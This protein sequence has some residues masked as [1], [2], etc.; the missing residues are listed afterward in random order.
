MTITKNQVAAKCIYVLKR[1]TR[2]TNNRAM[3]Q[4]LQTHIDYLSEYGL[5]DNYS[6][7]VYSNCI[8]LL[9]NNYTSEP[10]YRLFSD[11]DLLIS[12]FDPELRMNDQ[13][14]I[15]VHADG[16]A[17][18]GQAIHGHMVGDAITETS[19]RVRG[20]EVRNEYEDTRPQYAA[21]V[22]NDYSRNFFMRILK[23]DTIGRLDF[24]LGSTLLAIVFAISFSLL[25]L[26]IDNADFAFPA[27]ILEGLICIAAY[28]FLAYKR[29]GDMGLFG[30]VRFIALLASLSF[31]IIGFIVMLFFPTRVV[32]S[33]GISAHERA[34]ERAKEIARKELS[35]RLQVYNGNLSWFRLSADIMAIVRKL[36]PNHKTTSSRHPVDND[37]INDEE[38]RK[39]QEQEDE[40]ERK[41]QE[42]EDEEERRRQEQEERE[43]EERQEQEERDRRRSELRS[44]INQLKSELQSAAF[45][46]RQEEADAERCRSQADS[47]ASYARSESDDSLRADYESR[48]DSYYSDASNYESRAR[49]YAS[50]VARYESE[51]SDLENELSSI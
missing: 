26:K 34:E 32:L 17:D 4:R 22:H 35:S 24:F 46:Q 20:K 31:Q 27:L 38:E 37:D 36:E 2:N 21:E 14:A 44:E 23:N 16:T 1:Q 45:R 40:E 13:E 43:E 5:M 42:Q 3:R 47:Y 51:I 25:I 18:S 6:L 12:K 41:R 29:I 33:T 30:F 9:A 8:T 50:E 19:K 49:D 11:G 28:I 7:I 39:R 48:A 15:R 10:N